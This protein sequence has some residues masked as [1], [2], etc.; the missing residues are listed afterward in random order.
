MSRGI[1]EKVKGSG[2]Y[3]IRYADVDGKIRREKAG[4]KANAH[5]LR[6]KRK[7]AVLEGRKLPETS[8]TNRSRSRGS[9]LRRWLIRVCTSEVSATTNTG[10]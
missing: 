9:P 1:Y 5:K 10:W 4:T 2:E 3:W 6:L 8:G 7:A